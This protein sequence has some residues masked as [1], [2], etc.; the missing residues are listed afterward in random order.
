MFP[1]DLGG[2]VTSPVAE[3][4]REIREDAS[5]LDNSRKQIL[6]A[7]TAHTLFCGKYAR[8]DILPTVS[9]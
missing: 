6:H 1:D 7:I 3:H 8:P 5:K 9:F 2:K 4:L